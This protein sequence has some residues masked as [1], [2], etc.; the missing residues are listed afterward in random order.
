MNAD[1]LLNQEEPIQL[2]C[3]EYKQKRDTLEAIILSGRGKMFLG[4]NYTPEDIEKMNS[5][6]INQLYNK[7]RAVFGG[8]MAKSLGKT[9]INLYT[10][11]VTAWLPIESEEELKA[12][13]E[14][15][16][17]VSNSIGDLASK[18]YGQ[19]GG[20]LAPIITAV[21]TANNINFDF[22]KNGGNENDYRSAEDNSNETEEPR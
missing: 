7:Y 8:R 12:S 17:V 15:D 2:S 9:L 20:Y 5:E 3:G 10:K 21:I 6:E 13:L 16:L 18:L 19:F 11:L 14:S 22:Y 4:G 1:E